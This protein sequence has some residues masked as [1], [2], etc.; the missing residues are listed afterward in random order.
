MPWD[1]QERFAR[2]FLTALAG[3]IAGVGMIIL[4]LGAYSG[5]L[6][7]FVA[8]VRFVGLLAGVCLGY[9]L[10]VGGLAHGLAGLVRVVRFLIMRYGDK[11][12][13]QRVDD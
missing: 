10:I 1:E 5:S 9:A 11:R 3:L 7:V 2:A 8:Y 6:E 12:P 4:A 13:S